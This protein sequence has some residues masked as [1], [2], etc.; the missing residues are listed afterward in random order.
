M[1]EN[2]KKP[3][4]QM[5]LLIPF[6]IAGFAGCKGPGGK[7]PKPGEMEKLPA[8]LVK[9]MTVKKV[10]YVPE[11]LVS[12]Q[13]QPV[14]E[15]MLSV[16]QPGRLIVLPAEVGETVL[17]KRLLARVRSI[18]LWSRRTQVAA[19]VQEIETSL[20]Q[21]ESD[22]KKVRELY[23]RGAVTAR[24]LETAELMFNTRKTQLSQAKAGMSQI[25]ESLGGTSLFAPFTGEIAAKFQEVGNFVNMGTPL[26]RLVD[27]STIRVIVG[28]SE[29]DV[30][31][32]QQGAEV[33]LAPLAYPDRRIRGTIH[34]ISPA[35]DPALGAFPV[36]IRFPNVLKVPLPEGKW[37]DNGIPL[38]R[39]W[40]V[41]SGMT[42]RVAI[43]KTPVEG[44]F[45]PA[46]AVV[47]R[48]DKLLVFVA[49]NS[50]NDQTE[51]PAETRE[52]TLG[53]T[54]EGWYEITSGL[55]PGV[56]VIIAGNTKLRDKAPVRAHLV[57]TD[58]NRALADSV[59]SA[60]WAPAE[61][62]PAPSSNGEGTDRGSMEAN[63]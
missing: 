44:I 62:V 29:L 21:T 33:I 35:Q 52:V 51:G 30:R 24:D 55:E 38:Q 50:V 18:G 16:E 56:R 4:H 59:S 28:V 63:P 49:G 54:Y 6:L 32:I 45:V 26:Y 57:D 60:S 11:I 2:G 37:E 13:A 1:M 7:P 8:P 22:F 15:V 42:L 43:G 10:T 3:I 27:L 61:P 5:F 58:I 41:L 40:W 47:E 46:E 17:E 34:A 12:G 25:D 31:H 48:M 36:E 20:A 23:D 19:Q 14:R 9:V 39:K 53:R